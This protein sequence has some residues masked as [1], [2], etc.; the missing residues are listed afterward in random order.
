MT[1]GDR[2]EHYWNQLTDGGGFRALGKLRDAGSTKA[3]GLGVNEWQAVHDAMQVFDIDVTM[4]AGRYPLLEQ[5]S[6]DLM[7]DRS[8]EHPSEH[9]SLI[10]TPYAVFCLK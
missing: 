5:D 1:H 6:L 7:D 2:H 3:V 8:E 4:L 10:R 9:Q